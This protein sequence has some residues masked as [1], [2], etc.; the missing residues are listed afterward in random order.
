[1]VLLIYAHPHH[2]QSIANRAL[3]DAVRELPGVTLHPLYDRYPDFSIDV[4]AEQRRLKEARAIVWQC[5]TYWYSVPALMKLWIDAVLVRGFAYGDGGTALHGKP[6]L[7][8]TTTGSEA[9]QY[10][11]GQR[12]Q[13]PFAEL[14]RHIEQTARFCG[15]DWQPPIVLHGAHRLASEALAAAAYAYRDRVLALA[16]R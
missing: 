12:H 5:P 14:T 4:A 2:G 16:A 6:L 13:R 11:D 3:L 15:L 8:V 9:A 7:W 1:M 10:A